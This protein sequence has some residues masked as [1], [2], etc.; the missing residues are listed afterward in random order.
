MY[1]TGDSRKFAI[2]GGRLTNDLE[3][4]QSSMIINLADKTASTNFIGADLT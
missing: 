4:I 1:I 3:G 2:G